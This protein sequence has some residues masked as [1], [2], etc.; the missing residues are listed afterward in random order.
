MAD[1]K[2]PCPLCADSENTYKVSEI[3]IQSLVRLKHGDQAEAPIIDRLQAEIPAFEER[4]LQ[5][6]STLPRGAMATSSYDV[7]PH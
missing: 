2:K 4:L 3:Y 5:H 7:L 6:A 1:K